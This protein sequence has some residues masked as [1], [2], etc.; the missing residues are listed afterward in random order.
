MT[1]DFESC[2][3]HSE[4]LPDTKAPQ[5]MRAKRYFLVAL[6]APV[7]LV[8]CGD[9]RGTADA[10]KSAPDEPEVF[11][12]SGQV[13]VPNDMLSMMKSS[14]DGDRKAMQVGSPCRGAQ[15]YEDVAQGVQ[16]TVRDANGTTLALG[17]LSEGD[18]SYGVGEAPMDATCRLAFA[19][20]DVPAGEKFYSIEVSDRGD[21]AYPEDEL[22]EPVFL[23]L[24]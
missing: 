19:I 9:D 16:V 6:L 8:G 4:S 2:E 21:V 20:P 23:T 11:E 10:A 12:V 15:G 24:K 5:Y 22:A 14:M 7:W 18:L 13:E 1:P 17:E 3:T